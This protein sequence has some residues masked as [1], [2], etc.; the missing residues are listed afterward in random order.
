[1][2]SIYEILRR[3]LVTEK[4][5]YQVNKLHQYVFEVT[6]DSTRTMVKDA[7]EQIFDV[8]VVKVNIV[9][10]PAKRTRRARSR[11]LAVRNPGY[12]KAIVTLAPEDN[13]AIFEGV[14]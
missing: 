6:G 12:K 2:T 11:R 14:E 10:V 4:T 13:I 5:N 8:K 1:M 3:P 9:N 7:V